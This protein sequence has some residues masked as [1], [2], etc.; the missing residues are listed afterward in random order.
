[1]LKPNWVNWAT[2]GTRKDGTWPY[3]ALW[4]TKTSG[5]GSRYIVDGEG[6]SWGLTQWP[7]DIPRSFRLNF[8]TAKKI[9]S[10]GS[11]AIQ[12]FEAGIYLHEDGK[13]NILQAMGSAEDVFQTNLYIWTVAFSDTASGIG[14]WI[15]LM[16][17][18]GWRATHHCRT[19]TRIPIPDR[20]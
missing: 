20:S 14:I 11:S 19:M 12:C 8:E 10:A 18:S 13:S 17:G 7:S 3:L 5:L 16:A 1:M 15:C 6:S 4:T 2:V 9:S